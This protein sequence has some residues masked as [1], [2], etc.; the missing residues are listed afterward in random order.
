[1]NETSKA[2]H[3]KPAKTSR[4]QLLCLT[5]AGI[6][7]T[8]VRSLPASGQSSETKRILKHGEMIEAEALA[9]IGQRR[10]ALERSFPWR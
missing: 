4:R 1:M 7:L 8:L 3:G 9:V 6:G 10:R 5:G 2:S